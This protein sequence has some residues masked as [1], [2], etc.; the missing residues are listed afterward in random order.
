M[1]DSQL[2]LPSVGHSPLDIP[3]PRQPP[4]R[5]ILENNVEKLKQTD[6]HIKSEKQSKSVAVLAK[7]I[8]G[9]GPPSAECGG[10]RSYIHT[11]FICHKL[12]I[13]DYKYYVDR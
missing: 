7:T 6:E 13:V 8:W 1:T 11:Y 3:P 4:P 2:S 5:K 10:G 9:T 12:S